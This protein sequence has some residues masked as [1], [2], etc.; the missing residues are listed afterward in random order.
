MSNKSRHT[1]GKGGVLN[2]RQKLTAAEKLETLELYLLHQNTNRVADRL[3]ISGPAVRDR[4]YA[5][6]V[7]TRGDG[8]AA[9]VV[10]LNGKE[11]LADLQ[12]VLRRAS[13]VT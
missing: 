2:P 4:L 13:D 1:R 10:T 3:G 8:V 12:R 7:R 6:G 9:D 5:M 11:F